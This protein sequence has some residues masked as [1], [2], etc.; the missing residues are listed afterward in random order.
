MDHIRREA[1]R[2]PRTIKSR[3][4]N[5][6]VNCYGGSL[7]KREEV[8][9]RE[10]AAVW[11]KTKR[12]FERNLKD[13]DVVSFDIFDTLLFRKLMKPTDIFD[14]MEIELRAEGFAKARVYAE[15]RARALS[16]KGEVT[17]EEIYKYIPLRFSR[18]L[19]EE[20][21]FERRLLIS[22]PLVADLYGM[23]RDAGKRI[24]AVSDMYLDRDFLRRTLSEQG[25][26]ELEWV[27]VSSEYG[28]TKSQGKL[29]FSV[30]E[31]LKV[32]PRRFIHVG[33][34]YRSDV[35][36]AIEAGWSAVWVPRIDEQLNYERRKYLAS[37]NGLSVSIHNSLVCRYK[38]GG[39]PWYEYGYMLG[40]PIVLSYLSWIIRR[41]QDSHV[42]HLA[43]VGRDGWIL[44]KMY[45]SY[46]RRENLTSSYVYLP[47]SVSLLATLKHNG[48][49]A[50]VSY[51]LQKASEDGVNGVSVSQT[52]EENMA[53]VDRCYDQ[54]LE[55]SEKR[56]QELELHL[57]KRV[58]EN[59]AVALVDL[60]TKWLTSFSA[61]HGILQ[62]KNPTNFALCFVGDLSLVKVGDL[63]F[64]SALSDEK[65]FS[66]FND[67]IDRKVNIV[68]LLES[69]VSS[70][71]NRIVGLSGG[72]P[73][74]AKD[75]ANPF[76]DSIARGI[77]DYV[78]DFVKDYPLKEQCVLPVEI[79]FDIIKRFATHLS[80][81]DLKVLSSLKRS[82]NVDN[83]SMTEAIV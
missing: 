1:A 6:F 52:E 25:Y 9:L 29:F 67:R 26:K 79:A 10:K 75:G 21:S 17:L 46:L 62:E 83:K 64:E 65:R 70:P 33:D 38:D 63:P 60:T 43:F 68:T 44:K 71:E 4:I 40:G 16:K 12:I 36:K 27:Y 39:D 77:E 24:V 73:V 34:N 50:Y 47:R 56:R 18:L 72:E 5:F 19:Y 78:I 7:R 74:F 76:Y 37:G 35:E 42:E 13:V 20:K 28:A 23:A 22:N 3:I 30:A 49:G 15:Q 41:T 51:I 66:V 14:L 69:I 59:N 61:A 55:W 82:G 32:S 58:G 48:S 2:K 81:S 45:D 80:F 8:R 54:L 53:T 57:N 31:H 11:E